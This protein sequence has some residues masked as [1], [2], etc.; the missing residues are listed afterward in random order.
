M[1]E[2]RRLLS[3]MAKIRPG[4]LTAYN[5][6]LNPHSNVLTYRELVLFLRY[7]SSEYLSIFHDDISISFQ[8]HEHVNFT[9]HRLFSELSI[10][11]RF[12]VSDDIGFLTEASTAHYLR[13]ES[14]LQCMLEVFSY[15]SN[16]YITS[17]LDEVQAYR[18]FMRVNARCWWLHD[19]CRYKAFLSRVEDMVIEQN[20]DL[21][22]EQE[23]R[24]TIEV[25]DRIFETS[26][27]LVAKGKDRVLYSYF[28]GDDPDLLK[29]PDHHLFVLR[30]TTK[31][32][33]KELD[34]R[35]KL[36]NNNSKKSKRRKKASKL[37]TSILRQQV[38]FLLF[39]L[40][41]LAAERI[42]DDPDLSRREFL[43]QV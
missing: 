16:D 3:A 36:D 19:R 11:H 35:K 22:A 28:H 33:I 13:L 40:F 23:E 38:L 8:R 43:L 12:E 27:T 39:D 4:F 24:I 34:L 10:P 41:G 42:L 14:R 5:L 31:R 25:R 21:I 32:L 29:I 6:P 20:E 2:R 1:V 37:R 7:A 9:L 30:K 18:S 15:P 17:L 26:C